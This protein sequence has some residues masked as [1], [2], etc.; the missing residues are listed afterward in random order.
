MNNI[1]PRLKPAEIIARSEAYE[2]RTRWLAFWI[3]LG[4]LMGAS[5]T[6][7]FTALWRR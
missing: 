7:V 6:L 4:G 2:R 5:A 1:H 3:L